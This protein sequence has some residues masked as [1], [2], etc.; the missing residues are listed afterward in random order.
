MR[1]SPKMRKEVY[2]NNF[3][4]YCKSFLASEI[5]ITALN[6]AKIRPKLK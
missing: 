4:S 3:E 6:F 2:N 5:Y 1:M